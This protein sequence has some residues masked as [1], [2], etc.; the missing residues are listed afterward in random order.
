M[1][2]SAASIHTDFTQEKRASYKPVGI[3]RKDTII[4]AMLVNIALLAVLF[5]TAT[6]NPTNSPVTKV[7]PVFTQVEAISQVA[8]PVSAPIS[9]QPVDEIDEILKSYALKTHK[10]VSPV[11][12]EAPKVAVEQPS[13]ATRTV[14]VK[15]GDVL[16]R[17]AKQ[18]GV[19][20]EDI[21]AL[22]NLESLKL[23]I[24][25]VLKVPDTST[26]APTKVEGPDFYVVKEGDSPWK[27]AKKCHISVEDLLRLN[28]LDEA[29]A[30]NLKI[31]QKL[32]IR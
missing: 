11:T 29:K 5:A 31:G 8:A 17:I 18:N 10:T 23:Q 26:K 12:Q 6:R 1:Q 15:K 24:G 32:R 7:E 4:I 14:T 3:T 20:V 19:K 30:K 9:K 27:I 2:L 25:Q 13:I 16:S 22:N 28:N 21:I